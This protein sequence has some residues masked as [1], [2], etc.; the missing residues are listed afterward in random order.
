[1]HRMSPEYLV[2]ML[3]AIPVSTMPIHVR[4]LVVFGEPNNLLAHFIPVNNATCI[5]PEIPINTLIIHNLARPTCL[6]AARLA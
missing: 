5:H 3:F 4:H 1:M 6:A 2:V